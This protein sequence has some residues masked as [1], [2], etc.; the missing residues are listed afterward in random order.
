[1]KRYVFFLLLGGI[2]AL[3][4][5]S[6][7]SQE[8]YSI[9][10]EER[11]LLP[12]VS[13]ENAELVIGGKTASGEAFFLSVDM[14][15]DNLPGFSFSC[16][17]PWMQ[18]E[19]LYSG[20]SLYQLL[21]SIGMDPGAERVLLHARNDYQIEVPL[22]QIKKYRYQLT[23]K[24]DGRYFAELPDEQNKGPLSISIDFRSYPELLAD[25]RKLEEVWWLDRIELR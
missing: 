15:E 10:I 24:E 22:E 13:P 12:Q 17:D 9:N 25:E 7:K 14:I 23:F 5:C 4:L 18:K 21:N 11:V 19:T 20:V 16:I 8:K 1:M 6:C 2:L 3:S